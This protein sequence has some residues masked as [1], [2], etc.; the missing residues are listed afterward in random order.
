ME[1]PPSVH[2]APSR[3][4]RIALVIDSSLDHVF[5]VGLAVNKICSLVPLSDSE[6]FQVELCVVEA[7]NNAIEHAYANEPGHPVTIAVEI[8]TDRLVFK[9]M[10]TGHPID[11]DVL[12]RSLEEPT[13][14]QLRAE[15]GRGMSIMRTFMDCVSYARTGDTNVL[16]LVK[17]L[18]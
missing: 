16:T 13:A 17:H 4:G 7:V 14:A 5:L 10:S 15:R 3:T 9:V 12:Q 2:R 1:S 6:T 18:S 11:G 8:D